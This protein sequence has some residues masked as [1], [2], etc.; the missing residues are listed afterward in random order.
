MSSQCEAQTKSGARCQKKTRHESKRCHHHRDAPAYVEEMPDV[1]K[2][3]PKNPKKKTILSEQSSDKTECCVC[4]EEMSV[5]DNLDCGHGVCRVCLDQLRNDKCPMCRS[6]VK[7]KH[8]TTKM[9]RQ[10]KDRFEADKF[11]RH[12]LATQE[13]LATHIV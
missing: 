2:T 10:M 3:K 1:V 4:L 11:H 5:S 13:Y 6:D 8:I 7:A 12:F 9:K